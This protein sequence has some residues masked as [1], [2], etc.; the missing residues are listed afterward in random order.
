MK[1]RNTAIILIS[2]FFVIC[3]L[4]AFLTIGYSYFST[5]FAV[6]GSIIVRN[7]ND[8]RITNIVKN[9]ASN[10]TET[11][12]PSYTKQTFSGGVNMTASA[13]EIIYDVT[14]TNLSSE[15]VMLT[16]VTQESWSNTNAQYAL[17]NIT[18]NNTVIPAASSYTFQVKISFTSNF[19]SSLLGLIFG[20]GTI[21]QSLNFRLGFDFYK[22][23]KYELNIT[24]VPN[25]ALIVFEYN[26]EVVNTG[27]GSLS[28]RFLE[29]S[30]VKWTVSKNDY[31][32]QSETVTMTEDTIRTIS[33]EQ[34]GNYVF[35]INP[36]PSDALVTISANG[37][38]L[39][40]GYGSTSV[41]VPSGT[42]IT[43]KVSKY[44]FVDEEATYTMTRENHSINVTL[45]S[46]PAAP[47]HWYAALDPT[48]LY[49]IKSKETVSSTSTTPGAAAS[50][51]SEK[52]FA[53]SEDNYGTTYYYRGAITGNYVVFANMCWR[54]VRITG[55][56][57]IKL[58][59]F[60]NSS[61]SCTTTGSSLAF[62]GTGTFNSNAQNN[63]Y[64]GFMYG[65]VASGATYA[66]THENINPSNILTSL[67]TW[68]DSKF[69]NQTYESKLADVIWCNDKSIST[70]STQDGSN[71][72]YKTYYGTYQRIEGKSP[73]MVCPTT[74]PAGLSA[75]TVSDTT[76]GNGKLSRKIGLLT[77]DELSFGGIYTTI[78]LGNTSVY[79]NA[80]ATAGSWWTL[81]PYDYESGGGKM[82]I[83]K[84]NTGQ[85]SSS[86]KTTSVYIRPSIALKYDTVVSSGSGTSTSPYVIE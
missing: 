6:D 59:L 72:S 55:D 45:V 30:S 56:G 28:A 41:S 67:Q 26:N 32:T 25:D 31:E 11:V 50:S 43:Y 3:V 39:E 27:Y 36:N 18:L 21:N 37:S 60:N 19:I 57:S 71:T 40:S 44:L 29:N 5:S 24:S 9:S 80:N 73:S 77:M 22:I 42:E 48:L 81:S 8:I 35:T 38:V 2:S 47:E 49:K 86:V 63:A 69:L 54:I 46:L 82:Y 78:F 70:A 33:L 84:N 14:L 10:T 16:G 20:G 79:L 7:D 85:S 12:S 66:Q 17:Q 13:S 51:S 4:I 23:P 76:Y 83:I 15:D 53:S 65:S 64:L 74:D 68:Y 62:I 1:K 52:V 61:S 75:F 58:V 34:A